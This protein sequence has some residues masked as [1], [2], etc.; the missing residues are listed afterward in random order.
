MQ[1]RRRHRPRDHGPAYR[2][3]DGNQRG[4]PHGP[5]GVARVD[6][7]RARCELIATVRAA[8]GRSFAGKRVDAPSPRHQHPIVEIKDDS[9]IVVVSTLEWE[10]G[11]GTIFRSNGSDAQRADIF[12]VR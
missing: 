3:Y 10:V 2:A 5:L 12:P 4:P 8:A 6:N 1:Y 11:A 7:L 9:R